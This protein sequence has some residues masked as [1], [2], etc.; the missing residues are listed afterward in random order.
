MFFTRF[1]QGMN[2]VRLLQRTSQ[3]ETLQ[4]TS[5]LSS[6]LVHCGTYRSFFVCC[7]LTCGTEQVPHTLHGQPA[8]CWL[9]HRDW[10]GTLITCK[11]KHIC[12]SDIKCL[13]TQPELYFMDYLAAMIQTKWELNIDINTWYQNIY[14]HL[15]LH[16]CC[17]VRLSWVW[18]FLL[19]LNHG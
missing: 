8:H 15:I 1:A 11:K 9:W 3:G 19:H 17:K 16:L 10:Q 7:N 6:S 12:E 4:T 14:L 18:R 2:W 5:G 13:N